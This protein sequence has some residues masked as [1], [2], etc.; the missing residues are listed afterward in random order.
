VNDARASSD[1]QV[2]LNLVDASALALP[3]VVQTQ[4]Y[5][6][7]REALLNVQRHARA[8]RVQITVERCNGLARFCIQDDGRGFQPEEVDRQQ[9]L[10]LTIM[11]TRAERCGGSLQVESTPGHGTRIAA[12]LTAAEMA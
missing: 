8:Q 6:I 3:R 5:H 12:D 10:G 7:V 9:H 2:E 1:L 11:R 4:A